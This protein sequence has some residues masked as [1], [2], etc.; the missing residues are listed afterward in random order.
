[1]SPREGPEEAGAAGQGLCARREGLLERRRK[2]FARP[3]L[4]DAARAACASGELFRGG[5]E[6]EG[7]GGGSRPRDQ[8]SARASSLR[9]APDSRGA[10]GGPGREKA[11]GI[12]GIYQL[13]PRC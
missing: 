10:A 5:E 9:I 4:D 8:P 11:R 2:D 1:M 13:L 6:E 12:E 3:G 7:G